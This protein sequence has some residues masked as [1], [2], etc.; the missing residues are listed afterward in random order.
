MRWG[1]VELLGLI[2][3][4]ELCLSIQ[5]GREAACK[6]LACMKLPITLFLLLAA[7]LMAQTAPEASPNHSRQHSHRFEDTERWVKAWESPERDAQQRPDEVI[8][9]LEIKSGQVV[10]DIGAGS[11]YFARRFATAV[12]PTGKVLAVDIEPGLLEYIRHRAEQEGQANLT[13]VL[14]SETDPKLAPGSVDLV[15]VC[16]TIHHFDDRPAYIQL[17]KSALRPGGRVVVVDYRPEAVLEHG[18]PAW[19][20]LPAATISSELESAG[21]ATEILE[22]L[23]V[24]YVVI[25][26]LRP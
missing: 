13:T 15:F 2:H 4:G 17:M 5:E 14:A 11:G 1:R 9:R 16:N 21:L 22:F 26:K 25:G 19:M 23:P 3:L 7:S 10:A 24:Q 8:R 18:P 20:R 12:G 6:K